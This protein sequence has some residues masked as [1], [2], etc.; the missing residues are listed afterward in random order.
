M[1]RQRVPAA[2]NRAGDGDL[3]NPLK[4]A[5]EML[6]DPQALKGMMPMMKALV[7]DPAKLQGMLSAA[8]AN[9]AVRAMLDAN[10]DLRKAMDPELMRAS[11]DAMENENVFE[12]MMQERGEVMQNMIAPNISL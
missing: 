5:Q 3:S 4:K 1:G 12:A 8:E 10:P 2:E 9:P 7:S 11:V 6:Q